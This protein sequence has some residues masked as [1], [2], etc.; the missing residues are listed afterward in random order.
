MLTL[1][2]DT[3][4]NHCAVAI[5]ANGTTAAS[6][7]VAVRRGHGEILMPMVLEALAAAGC[8]LDEVTVFAAATGPGSFTGIRVGL[9]AV[10]GM[11][12]GLD[13]PIVGVTVFD[14]TAARVPPPDTGGATL[15]VALESGREDLFVQVFKPDQ[16]RWTP[17]ADP[18]A[19]PPAALMSAV[20]GKRICL[21]GTGQERAAAML[22]AHEPVLLNVAKGTGQAEIIAN[23][24]RSRQR[25]GSKSIPKALYIRGAD[26][27]VDGT[28]R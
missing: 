15:V 24:A 27:T 25:N 3:T 2:I 11:A 22:S 12:L 6:R 9:A 13:R 20:G 23:I 17:A 4:G 8:R 5:N 19:V 14:A 16:G 18:E 26:V 7:L 21:V 28:N 10:G 1:A